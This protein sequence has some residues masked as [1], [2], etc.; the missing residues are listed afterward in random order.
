MTSKQRFS[1][2]ETETEQIVS[3]DLRITP[4]E[5]ETLPS[6]AHAQLAFLNLHICPRSRFFLRENGEFKLDAHGEPI[7]A[8]NGGTPA[9]I[10]AEKAA[11]EKYL[12]APVHQES[13]SARVAKR[14]ADFLKAA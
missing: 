8:D 9:E 10:A 12:N 14:V 4:S 6:T 3:L 2:W 13:L 5:T 11:I 7:Y 1:H